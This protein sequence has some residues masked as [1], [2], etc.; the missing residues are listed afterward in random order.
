MQHGSPVGGSPAATSAATQ[1]ATQ[2]SISE[3]VATIRHK[4]HP[5]EAARSIS[6][7]GIEYYIPPLQLHLLLAG[8]A[9]AIAIG[10]FGVTIRRWKVMRAADA[11]ANVLP[12]EL[13]EHRLRPDRVDRPMPPADASPGAAVIPHLF[14]ARLWLWALLFALGTAVSGLWMTDD[15]RLKVLTEP[16]HNR[17]ALDQTQRLFGHVVVGLSIALLLLLGAVLT[18]LAKRHRP[19]TILVMLLATIAVAS[20]MW[21]GV[22]LLFDSSSGL[23]TKFN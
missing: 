21:L 4:T 5:V 12:I 19:L 20:Q 3:I 22:L 7:K 23:L 15:W 13:L 17:F 8:I 10:A 18:R 16:M 11:S 14:P 1:P 6:R 9:V 2:R